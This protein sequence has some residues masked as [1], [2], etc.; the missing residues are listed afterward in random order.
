MEVNKENKWL[1]FVPPISLSES[2]IYRLIEY[3]K[4]IKIHFCLYQF[5]QY[6]IVF[7]RHHHLSLY[8]NDANIFEN[9]ML[10][11]LLNLH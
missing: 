9:V 1:Q 6:L 3:I 4:T 10:Q 5:V 7:Q 2:Y 11:Y 8:D